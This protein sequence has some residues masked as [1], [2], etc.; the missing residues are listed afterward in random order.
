MSKK[1]AIP[2][3]LSERDNDF[4]KWNN[5]YR[6]PWC[7][8]QSATV[9]WPRLCPF[10]FYNYSS[11]MSFRLTSSGRT[12]ANLWLR[13][14]LV[15]ECGLS[16]YLSVILLPWRLSARRARVRVMSFTRAL[17]RIIAR[18]RMLIYFLFESDMQCRDLSFHPACTFSFTFPINCRCANV[19]K[20]RIR[21][22]WGFKITPCDISF[23][24]SDRRGII[25]CSST[26]PLTKRRHNEVW[27]EGGGSRLGWLEGPFQTRC[28][29]VSGA[30]G[31]PPYS[32]RRQHR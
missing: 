19:G 27:H 10:V 21:L 14:F 26:S 18:A 5:S 4:N 12:S 28:I 9:F 29:N 23:L 13:K 20:P 7:I 1:S 31:F 16:G 2:G 6:E 15:Y 8:S 30:H 11:F 3:R 25:L 24:D 32:A 17:T 22:E